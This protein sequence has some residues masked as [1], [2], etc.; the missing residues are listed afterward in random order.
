MVA[1]EKTQRGFGSQ[2]AGC[3]PT[4]VLGAFPG[5]WA[6]R[7]RQAGLPE[8][9]HD[10][11]RALDDP[12]IPFEPLPLP[13]LE[14]ATPH[15]IGEAYARSLN[16]EERLKFGRHYTPKALADALWA[17]IDRT[18]ITLPT[19]SI[20]DPACGAGSLLIRP[21]RRFVR[22]HL[23]GDP[24]AALAGASNTFG[25]VD[26][27]ELAAWL[28]NAILAAELLPLWARIPPAERTS[29]PIL[30][31]PGDGLTPRAKEAG[32]VVMNPPYGRAPLDAAARKRWEASL[33]GHANWYGIFLHAAIERTMPGGLVAA[34]LPTSFLGGAYFQRLR[35]F[36]AANAPLVR[37]RRID[38]RSGVFASGVLQE[39]CLAVFAKGRRDR[40]VAVST[41]KVNGRVRS[42]SLG[43]TPVVASLAS[44]PWAFPRV[45][46]DRALVRAAARHRH[47]L[48]DYGWRASTGPLV[49]NRHKPQI[50]AKRSPQVVPILWGSDIQLGRVRRSPERDAQRW[51]RL[52]ERDGFMCLEDAAVLVQRTTA[53][54]QPRRLVSAPF[55]HSLLEDWG[56]VVVVENH[57]NVLRCEVPESPLSLS[58]LSAVL[59]TVTI[60]RLYRCM[61]GT[62]AVSA[63]ELEALALPVQEVLATW[64]RLSGEDLE[65]AVAEAFS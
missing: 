47:T 62:V 58:L 65:N 33:Y 25:G 34:V 9:W 28:G 46:E 27:D 29:L 6:R 10:W 13:A 64:E 61:T 20:F 42:V 36:V 23:D 55:P 39:T 40:H 49:W 53:P 51:I 16:P 59:N 30:L 38:D 57:V 37:L 15:A 43:R 14:R 24:W 60:D 4:E 54:E 3:S 44:R 56:G 5:W 18:N 35:E 19:T 32:I 63:F 7:A 48:R 22:A 50:S 17:E 31:R 8:A 21:L 41:Q 1:A 11:R 52:R 45:P 2:I 26:S 12:P